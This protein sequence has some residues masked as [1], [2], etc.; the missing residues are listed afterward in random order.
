MGNGTITCS[1]FTEYLIRKSEHLDD[2]LVRAIRPIDQWMGH[3]ETGVFPAMDGVS[4]TFDRIERVIPDL[5]GAW[6]D[7]ASESC[8][9]RACDKDEKVI[10][11]GST[12]DS[13]RLKEKHYATQLFCFDLIMSADRAK[14]QFASVVT[15]L[16]DAS[17]WITSDWLRLEAARVAGRKWIAAAGMPEFTYTWNADY[18][19][20]TVSALPTS[21]LT[22]SM[23]QRRVQPQISLGA[24]GERPVGTPMLLELCTDMDTLWSL[25]Q[26][27][28]PL[29]DRWRFTDFGSASEKFYKLGWQ[30]K[31]GNYAVRV[32]L[33]P[34]RFQIKEGTTLRR[35]YPFKTESTTIGIRSM[36]NERYDEAPI[37]W[38]YI[39]HRKAMKHLSR[40]VESVNPEMPFLRRDMGGKWMFV[41][42]NLGADENG[43][44]IENKRR[45]KGQ[46]IADFSFSTKAEHPE[47]EELVMHLREPVCV[48]ELALCNTSYVPSYTTESS[49]SAN[50]LCNRTFVF[51]PVTDPSEGY[52]VA[53]NTITCNGQAI[54]HAAI[55]SAADLAALVVLLNS[56]AGSIGTWAVV[57]GSATQIQVSASG[58]CTSVG[59]PFVVA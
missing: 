26:R 5:S 58:G 7:V 2:M 45:N 37:Q 56:V 35:V 13:Y 18:T 24:M 51:T 55:E 43:C 34:I 59:V 39:H 3:V 47:W 21:K 44:V 48:A 4:H 57:D 33:F 20:C 42:D 19:E 30:G 40:E 52:S 11:M 38:S 15:N 28:G 54:A 23:L 32:D 29:A 17:V 9:G 10:G 1:Q 27:D 50:A 46:F 49:G 22:A 25:E 36:P 31:V 12:R 41:M 53:A 16:R 14:E 8:V 6:N